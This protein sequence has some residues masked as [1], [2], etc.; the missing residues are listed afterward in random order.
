MC[1]SGGGG[2][3]YQNHCIRMVSTKQYQSIYLTVGISETFQ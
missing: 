1:V 2:G 3:W